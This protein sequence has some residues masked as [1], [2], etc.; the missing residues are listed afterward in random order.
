MP[1]KTFKVQHEV[2]AVDIQTMAGMSISDYKEYL[3]GGLIFVDHHDVLRSQPAG[4][5]LAVTKA[6]FKAL[7]SYLKGLESRVG[8]E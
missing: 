6:Q 1:Y 7:I 5:P 8:S 3:S 2:E 4:Y